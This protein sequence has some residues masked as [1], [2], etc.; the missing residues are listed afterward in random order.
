M[1]RGAAD[2]G[3]FLSYSP[4]IMLRLNHRRLTNRIGFTGNIC[5]GFT[6]DTLYYGDY[7]SRRI[8][9]SIPFFA[10]LV[11]K[12]KLDIHKYVKPGMKLKYVTYISYMPEY[13]KIIEIKGDKTS[14]IGDG[15]LTEIDTFELC[16]YNK[17]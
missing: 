4:G 1:C 17:I 3:G 5:L 13:I 6:I 2:L 16:N 11:F 14:V 8:Y 7:I 12:W 10:I 9:I 15:Q